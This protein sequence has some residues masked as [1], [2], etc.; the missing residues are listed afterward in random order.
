VK[1]PGL[2]AEVG[3]VHESERGVEIL[4]AMQ[5]DDRREGFGGAEFAVGGRVFEDGR[6]EALAGDFSA[7]D[8][9]RAGLHCRVDARADLVERVAG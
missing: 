5:R 1:T 7:A 9:L 3:G 4:V 6:L 2:Q 8:D